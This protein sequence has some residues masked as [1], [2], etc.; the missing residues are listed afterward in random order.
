MTEN[1]YHSKKEHSITIRQ[2]SAVKNFEAMLIK[3][4]EATQ[5]AHIRKHRREA[6]AIVSE[7]AVKIMNSTNNQLQKLSHPYHLLLDQNPTLAKTVYWTFLDT[8]VLNAVKLRKLL[9]LNPNV[10][11]QIFAKK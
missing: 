11:G 7:L 5:Y 10:K 8:Q 2:P 3:L 9:N 1:I 6:R 4:E